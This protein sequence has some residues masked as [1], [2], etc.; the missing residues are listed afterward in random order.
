ME[1]QPKEKIKFLDIIKSNLKIITST[2]FLLLVL[3]SFYSWFEYKEDIKKKNLSEKFIEAKIML[4]QKKNDQAL[5]ILKNIIEE[6]DNTYSVLSLYLIIDQNLEKNDKKIINYFD[7]ILSNS[8]LENE[9]L[10][11]V[12]FK[13]A[14]FISSYSDEKEMLDLLNPIINS[15]SVWK[16][17]SIKFLA[18]FYFS[19]KEYK[20]A[21][22][23]YS[24]L[25]ALENPNIDGKEIKRKIKTY[26][27]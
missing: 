17:Q 11:L 23:Y 12:K 10:D 3:I 7:K 5:N 9:D 13:K 14:I 21:D 8:N 2:I 25:L 18:D 26:K 1:D 16:V 4:S 19:K 20:K 24:T 6:E 15:D 22:Q 27:K